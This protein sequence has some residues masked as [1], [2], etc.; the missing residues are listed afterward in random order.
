M[1][2]C[3]CHEGHGDRHHGHGCSEH[4]HYLR[5]ES[6]CHPHH[7]DAATCARNEQEGSCHGEHGMSQD[8]RIQVL[9][10]QVSFM[11]ERLERLEKELAELGGTE[12]KHDGE[13]EKD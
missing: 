11:K 13:C 4:R 9:A 2:M 8:D 1:K 10:K 3:C 12:T 5:H 7:D 6:C